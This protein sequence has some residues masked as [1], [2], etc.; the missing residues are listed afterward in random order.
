MPHGM[1]HPS[2]LLPPIVSLA[3]EAGRE[4]LA[5]YGAGCVVRRKRDDS[6]LTTAD[7]AA[8][9]RIVAGLARLTPDIPWLSEESGD[10]SPAGRRRWSCFWLLDPLDGTR[11]FLNRNGEFTVNIALIRDGRPVLGVVHA[12]VHDTTY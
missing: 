2:D 10:S 8:H 5:I 3:R 11:E 6:P 4:I 12:P 9:R 7:L 1:A